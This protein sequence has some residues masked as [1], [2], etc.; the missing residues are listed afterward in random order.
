MKRRTLL[1]C[2]RAVAATLAFGALAPA[3]IAGD[4]QPVGVAPDAAAATAAPLQVLVMLRSPPAHAR[5]D[6]GYGAAGYG[7][8]ARA[9]SQAR[10]GARLAAAHGLRV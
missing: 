8:A 4:E 9:Q 1:G 6:G 7:D 3:A 5:I 10:V 2:L